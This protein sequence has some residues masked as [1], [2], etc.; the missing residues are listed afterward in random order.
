MPLGAPGD[1]QRRNLAVA[2]AA[3]EAFL[4]ALDDAAVR[5]AA[6]RVTVPGRLEVVA[7]QP[8]VVHDAAHNPAGAQALAEALPA[9]IADRPLVAVLGVLDDKD[10][11]GVLA[12][13]LALCD[14]AILTG[15]AHP[16]ALTAEALSAHA[17]ALGHG[18]QVEP[19]EEPAEAL[20]RARALAGADGAVLVAGSIHLLA[21]LRAERPRTRLSTL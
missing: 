14:R 5:R 16:R 11:A 12:P 19:S 10:A 7:H 1:F 3:A 4:G 17:G 6:A 9:L 8:L 21:E 13:L 18:G 15:F 2:R 20:E